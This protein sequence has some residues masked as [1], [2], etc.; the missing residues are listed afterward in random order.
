V[1]QHTQRRL[2]IMVA[3][4][5][6]PLW[7]SRSRKRAM[8]EELLAHV[9]AVFEEEL[10][11]LGDERVALAEA[12]DRFGLS[13]DLESELQQCVPPLERWLLISE[14]EILMSGWFWLVAVIAVFV[15]PALVMPAVAHF[16]QQGT[17]PWGPLLLGAAITLAGLG[18]VGYGVFRRFGT[19]A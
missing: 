14:R 8:Q 11:R 7:A 18:G 9:S 3:R 19:T 2:Q 12:V 5:V 1:N 16:N 6:R 10:A 15:G 13:E 17:M 4:A